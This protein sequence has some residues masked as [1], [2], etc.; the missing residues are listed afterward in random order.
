MSPEAALSLLPEDAPRT[1]VVVH[2]DG[3]EL[4]LG[5]YVDPRD[6]VDPDTIVEETS[7][8][9]CLAWHAVHDRRVSLLMLELQSEVDR[10]V[11]ARLQGRGGF[12]HFEQFRWM[13]GMSAATQELY[14]TAHRAG[15]RTCRSL[16]RRF[17][18][19]S[20]VPAMLAELRRF[21]R[22][23]AESKLRGVV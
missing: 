23:S 4:Q 17:P 18:E 6:S 8:L 21:Y 22:A 11:V 20:D 14:A 10:Y 3:T 13:D 15:L 12:R 19:R 2:D 1:G 9:L 7:H 5:L 16:A